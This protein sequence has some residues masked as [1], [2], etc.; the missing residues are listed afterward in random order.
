MATPSGCRAAGMTLGSPSDVGESTLIVLSAMLPAT[1]RS[2]LADSAT[3]CVARPLVGNR[4]TPPPARAANVSRRPSG[5][6]TRFHPPAASRIDENDRLARLRC[7]GDE[8][9][10]G[11]KL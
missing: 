1:I 11:K 9:I 8:R 2:P 3:M 7:H 10:P 6:R 4:L 5:G